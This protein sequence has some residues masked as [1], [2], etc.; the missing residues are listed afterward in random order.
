MPDVFTYIPE[1]HEY[2]RNG[3]PILGLT[4]IL[5]LNGVYEDLMALPEDVVKEAGIRGD[6]AHKACEYHDKGTLDEASV[7]EKVMPYLTSYR[8]WMEHA[9][10]TPVEIETIHYSAKWNYGCRLDRA[11]A[12]RKSKLWI[13]DLKA[14]HK[15]N[16]L[17]GRLQTAGQAIAFEEE[18]GEKVFSR[19]VLHLSKEG[20]IAQ[21]EPFQKEADNNFFFYCLKLAYLKQEHAPKKEYAENGEHT[22]WEDHAR[23]W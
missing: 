4:R 11:F 23:S 7:H 2:L 12:D 20:K 13:V 1:K 21:L 17:A 19:A 18:T 14:T 10:F 22:S 15:V 9:G 8:L 5:K 3:V 6:A 16:T